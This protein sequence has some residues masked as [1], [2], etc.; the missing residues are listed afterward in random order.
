MRMTH[1]EVVELMKSAT[2]EAD[3]NAKCDRVKSAFGGDYPDF[4]FA[5]IVLGGIYESTMRK[6]GAGQSACA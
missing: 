2:S 5:A 1:G 4:W 6:I 3:W